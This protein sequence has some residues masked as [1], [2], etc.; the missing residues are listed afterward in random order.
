MRIDHYPSRSICETFMLARR[1]PV[2]WSEDSPPAVLGEAQAQHYARE[3]FLLA[4]QLLDDAE[5]REL[6][7][8]ANQQRE[9]LADSQD[10]RVIFEPSSGVVRS[11]FA[12]HIED[13]LYQRLM[14]HPKILPIAEYLLGSKT[15]IHQARL[16]F[17]DGFDGEAFDW[18]SD[19]ETWH[20]EDGM[21]C[22]RAV[23]CL[24]ML[25]ENNEFNG[26]LMVIPGSHLQYIVCAGATP[27][28]NYRTSL[29][30]QTVGVPSQEVISMLTLLNGGLRSIKGAA[31]SVLFFDCNL[32]HGS[33]NNMSPFARSNLFFVY[34]SV[35]NALQQPFG[36]SR[37]RPEYIAHRHDIFYP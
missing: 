13:A 32:L 28:E 2:I 24:I 29:R 1:D 14:R 35:D 15:Y 18:H 31:G 5:V 20:C 3:G 16:N 30:K 10:E 12:P 22:M 37:P 6:R 7:T 8:Y 33:A 19:F 17:K 23:S 27:E 4:E 26:P 21:P 36:G 25:S 9:N 11:V 34:N